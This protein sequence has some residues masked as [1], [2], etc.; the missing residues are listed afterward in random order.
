[1]KSF[2]YLYIIFTLIIKYLI[3]ILIILLLHK[4]IF[5]VL[6]ICNN[7]I[8]KFKVKNALSTNWFYSFTPKQYQSLLTP[9]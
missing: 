1:M 5:Y 8:V 6:T 2:L 9:L 7:Y 3:V 4:I